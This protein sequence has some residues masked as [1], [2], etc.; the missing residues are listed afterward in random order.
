MLV[1][2]TEDSKIR[3][4][5]LNSN[6][7]VRSITGHADSVSCIRSLSCIGQ[8][9]L[10]VSGGHD[11]AVRVWDIRTFQLLHDNH[12]HRPKYDEGTLSLALSSKI[13]LLATGGADSIIR[14]VNMVFPQTQQ[15]S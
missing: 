12:L 11:G 1:A 7:L 9:N 13:P 5:D 4:F 15:P 3:F 8:P 2:G 14:I 6:Q 10:I